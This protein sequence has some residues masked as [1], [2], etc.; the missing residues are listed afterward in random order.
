[1]SRDYG[2]IFCDAVNQLIQSSLS[3]LNYDIT[4]NCTVT[5]IDDR[6]CGKYQ[7]FDGA[8][9]FNAY[10]P[11]GVF[12]ELN[13]SV[14]VTIPE[15]DF[16][17]QATIINKIA[18]PFLGSA[19]YKNPFDTLLKGTEN[20]CK[21]STFA[22]LIANNE[23]V[24]VIPVTTIEDQEFFGF[25]KIGLQADFSALLKG[26]NVVEG[27]YGL[28]LMLY[29]EKNSKSSVMDFTFSSYD[30]FGNPYEFGSGFKQ[31][32]VFDIPQDLNHIKKIEVIFYQD[33]GFKNKNGEKIQPLNA[34]N[35]FVQNLEIYFGYEA[36]IKV[37]E[38]VEISSPE[39]TYVDETE[40]R[41]YLKWFHQVDE[42]TLR[43]IQPNDLKDDK[44]S[45]KWYQYKPGCLDSEMDDYGGMNWKVLDSAQTKDYPLV[46]SFKPSLMRMQEKIKAIV[47]VNN[48][49][50]V[51]D[52][53]YI[54][55]TNR[56]S[57]ILI[58][59]NA[60]NKTEGGTKYTEVVENKL[61]L[62]FED[63]SDG[64]Y[65]LYDQNGCLINNT[66]N[67]VGQIRRIS[68]KYGGEDI[69]NTDIFEKIRSITW[70]AP[71]DN[72]LQ[73]MI[74]YDRSDFK[75]PNEN[76]IK[77]VDRLNMEN[78]TAWRTLSD[79]ELKYDEDNPNA[80]DIWV[81]SDK[82]A[83]AIA[84][85]PKDESADVGIYTIVENNGIAGTYNFKSTVKVFS[86]EDDVN[87]IQLDQQVKVFLQV[88]ISKDGKDWSQ[89]PYSKT[90]MINPLE[91]SVI[92]TSFNVLQEH[93]KL[94]IVIGYSKDQEYNTLPDNPRFFIWLGQDDTKFQLDADSCVNTYYPVMD[95]N[96][97]KT[98]QSYFDYSIS[99]IWSQ[100]RSNN[101]IQC[102]VDIDGQVHTLHE[103]LQFGPRGSNGTH[104]TFLLEMLDG[105]NALIVNDEQQKTLRVKAILL[106]ASSKEIKIDVNKLSWELINGD[107]NLMEITEITNN[108]CTIT[109]MY[110]SACVPSNNYTI[111]RAKYQPT[112]GGPIL[113]AFLPIA[114]KQ[115]ECL[116]M[117]GADRVI[118]NH[119][120]TP[121]YSNVSYTAHM[122]DGTATTHWN[123][124]SPK[125]E[126]N[127]FYISPNCPSLSPSTSGGEA[128]VA[129]PLY[130]KGDGNGP[131]YDAV[132]VY[133][134]YWSQPIL[135]MQSSYDFAM[136]NEWDGSLTID[137]KN[138]TILA[139]ML[140]AGRKNYENKFSG[141]L[142]GDIKGGTGLNSTE[143]MTGVYG[144]QNGVMSYGLRENGTA[145]F[146]ADGHGR[147][148]IDGTSGIIRS[149]GW[150]KNSD[151]WVLSSTQENASGTLIDLDDGIF[152]AQTKNGDY[153]K[154]NDKNSGALEMSLSKLQIKM[155]NDGAYE[156]LDTFVSSKIDVSANELKTEVFS[157]RPS[158][159][160]HCSTPY[161]YSTKL[162]RFSKNDFEALCVL[163]ETDRLK[164]TWD[165]PVGTIIE[166]CC[167][168]VYNTESEIKVQLGYNPPGEKDPQGYPLIIGKS[169]EMTVSN[170]SNSST[171]LLEYSGYDTF[172]IRYKGEDEFEVVTP[173]YSAIRQTAPEISSVVEGELR[174]TA[175]YF[176]TVEALTNPM[177]LKLKNAP[178]TA[179]EFYQEGVSLDVTIGPGYS[180]KGWPL[181]FRALGRDIS[182]W[183]GGKET[184]T[185][186]PFTWTAGSTIHFIY[187]AQ[188]ETHTTGR[189]VI[190]DSG[191]YKGY[192]EVKQTAEGVKTT[193]SN[194]GIKSDG[195]IQRNSNTF[196]MNI[197]AGGF[198]LNNANTADANNFVFKCNG[199]GVVING[200][201]SFSGNLTAATTKFTKMQAGLFTV[202]EGSVVVNG[203]SYSNIAGSYATSIEAS[204]IIIATKNDKTGN[205]ARA[206]YLAIEAG[207]GSGYDDI[208]IYAKRIM[209]P[210]GAYSL[211]G[212]RGYGN[213][214]TSNNPWDVIYVAHESSVRELKQNIQYYDNVQAYEELRN[215]PLFTFRYNGE[216][217]SSRTTFLGTMIDYLPS[218][219]MRITPTYDGSYFETNSLIY[220]NIGACQVMQLKI[221][222][223]QKTIDDLLQKIQSQEDSSYGI[224]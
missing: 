165:L 124:N 152:I 62:C 172:S 177:E 98:I 64:N 155:D 120:G 49:P 141:V 218:E 181:Q 199:D 51:N 68:L 190:S 149:A 126:N 162:L 130:S 2:E 59:E 127:K 33:N 137:E 122:S 89:Y 151:E 222:E 133:C 166:V 221:E 12:Y 184:G 176:A 123:L 211:N 66:D 113:Q 143:K 47:F 101:F 19:S 119:L 22:G 146:G 135:I 14:L 92:N 205:D 23:E 61:S 173:S 180:D 154:F 220:W 71:D 203:T 117:T 140:G 196:T 85:I 78:L 128:L 48:R 150:E 18:D 37:E 79:R 105:K 202:P 107:S 54:V 41:I 7:V 100:E 57:N 73:S 24:P 125:D 112:N 139:T 118:Y 94:K 27:A 138:G 116:R 183:L 91:G 13:D 6:K 210:G 144:F 5:N 30:M 224:D 131:I 42:N 156:D 36:G 20:I 136:L 153:I 103:I 194:A 87:Q 191:S 11:S 109:N 97:N 83:I 148:E 32:I 216:G 169:N 171:N 38:R 198:Y 46:L 76:L 206:G 114:M 9:R 70:Q 132:C 60:D 175:T 29:A 189:W 3:T 84:S 96:G 4:K 110:G 81:I 21:Q 168:G 56:G 159:I 164:G 40:K 121:N 223:M 17:K 106:D 142:I 111:L 219:V 195:S 160:V 192:S 77:N 197:T 8:I 39:L 99:T 65:F 186:N 26:Q 134:D 34:S 188:N 50:L 200:G 69:K 72:I 82:S 35:L 178:S 43:I 179:D 80:D 185:S 74:S 28:K 25:T 167:D 212:V 15:G 90:F 129:A 10:A 88:F 201:G 16:N 215:L 217:D 213:I 67:G 31:Q 108:I 86:E 147:I 193:V 75:N 163:D 161:S 214:G 207:I 157:N 182:I 174:K 93:K 209:G 63:N 44:Y 45:I 115:K 208:T 104:N 158:Y 1:M 170:P 58:F 102:S 145:F 55:T 187:R 204:K 95:D 52:S 53:N